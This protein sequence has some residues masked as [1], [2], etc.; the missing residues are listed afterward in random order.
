MTDRTPPQDTAAPWLSLAHVPLLPCPPPS[1][2]LHEDIV[3]LAPDHHQGS[4]GTEKQGPVSLALFLGADRSRQ[5]HGHGQPSDSV[6]QPAV[7]RGDGGAG[8]AL[9]L[10]VFVTDG[11]RGGAIPGTRSLTCGA[12][13]TSLTFV[14]ARGVSPGSCGSLVGKGGCG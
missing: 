10:G 3:R 1:G 4:L 8:S 2:S 9:L 11:H 6:G 12:E 14:G 5:T 13:V 7:R